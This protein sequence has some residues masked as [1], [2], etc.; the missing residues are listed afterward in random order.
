MKGLSPLDPSS[1]SRPE[2]VI[3]TEIRLN[4]TVDFKKKTFKGFVDLTVKKLDRL[5]TEVVLDAL[6]LNISEIFDKDFKARLNYV[7]HPPIDL[8]GSKLVVTLPV[9]DKDSYNV[10][11]HYETSSKATGLQWLEPQQ[12]AGKKHPYV[13]SQ[14][15]PI[16]ARSFLPCQD[17]PYV[18]APY[19]ATITTSPE[20]TALMS[21]ICES[22]TTE[23]DFTVTK[24]VQKVPMCSYVIAIAIGAIKGKR[25]G[26]RTTVW[27]EEPMLEEVAYEF[28]N[29]EMQL[30]KAEEIC[31][32]YQWG[33]YD[34]LVLPPSFPYGGMENPCLNFITP[35]LL[36]GDRSLANGTAHEIVHSWT[37]N[38]IT[39]CNWEHFWLNEGFTVFIDRKILG[40]MVNS[41][42]Q[43]FEAYCGAVQLRD[44]ISELG[45][46]NPITCLVVDLENT[47][48]D[49]SYSL[50]PYE[51]GYIFLRYLEDL[52][53]GASE[54]EPFLRK[55]LHQF[56]F[57]TLN[58]T[59]FKSYFETYFINKSQ[60]QQ[61]D[62]N[63]W[64]YA[65]GMPPVIPSYDM[66]LVKLCNKYK[67]LW[68]SW[69]VTEEVPFTKEEI[70]ELKVTQVIQLLQD[71]VEADPQPI[72][73]LEILQ[74]LF[75]FAS[76]KNAEIKFRWLRIGLKA[77]WEPTI[78]ETIEWINVVGRMK[79]VRPLYRALYKW[80]QG[81]N[82]AI[83]NF[84]KNHQYMMHVTA[85]TVRKDL[86]IAE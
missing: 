19:K 66:T 79:F 8:Y 32:P 25:I 62:W 12:T 41:Q 81:R 42:E 36:A 82:A 56:Q 29:T 13:F 40:R 22:R 23:N 9:E 34:L 1:H 83:E 75:D 20:L 72:K 37:G 59:D 50:V 65:P 67:E 21:A 16:H 3:V 27:T 58:S 68:L 76:T 78:K 30:Q 60:I 48:P 18:K 47:H 84:H 46:D 54:F 5:A 55:Y 64:L 86:N 77:Q 71:V 38:S 7:I 28:A 6:D 49:D 17:T 10:R 11:I 51:K 14:L 52:V 24:F 15:Q 70:K 73:K 44:V 43:D 63:K 69:D 74:D 2:V 85:Y 45:E 61:I 33:I 80:R 53:G 31:G 39:S 35:T 26:P 57:K 4:L